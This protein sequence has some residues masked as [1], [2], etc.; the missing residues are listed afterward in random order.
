MILILL[1]NKWHFLLNLQ[2][3]SQILINT[4]YELNFRLVYITCALY[5]ISWKKVGQKLQLKIIVHWHHVA[6]RFTKFSLFDNKEKFT[7]CSSKTQ[8]YIA[9]VFS[10]SA[11]RARDVKGLTSQCRTQSGVHLASG[12]E[13]ESR[14]IRAMHSCFVT[15]TESTISLKAREIYCKAERSHVF[16]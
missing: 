15:A 9:P 1:W 13:A 7:F 8:L 10:S 16:Q 6:A 12:L 5:T 4:N 14:C 3:I 11:L 2:L